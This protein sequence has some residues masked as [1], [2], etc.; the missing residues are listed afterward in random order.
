M[1][2]LRSEPHN[3]KQARATVFFITI[4]ILIAAVF[5]ISMNTGSLSMS[6]LDVIRTLFGQGTDQQKLALF[7][8]RLPRIVI[9]L[10]IGAGLA[11][12][13]CLLQG[14]VR[15]PI[16]DPGILGVN[17]G[18]GVMVVL[19]ITYFPNKTIAPVW[20]LPCL[21]FIGASLA[22]LLLVMLA[23]K[24]NIGLSPTKLI[25]SGIAVAAG[26][27]AL[28]IVLTIQLDSDNYQFL[29][30]FLAGSIWG[31]DWRFV[32]AL[33]PWLVII[34]P[35]V[36]YKARV[37]DLLNLGDHI[38]TGLGAPVQRARLTFLAAAVALAASCV[39]VS[40]SIGFVGLIAPH[41]ARRLIGTTHK[42]LLP[43]SALLGAL[44]VLIADTLS[45]VIDI[46]AGLIVAML[47]APYFLYL[48]A[49]MR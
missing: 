39:A 10:L 26:L 8:F 25:L 1:N 40:G 43:A 12:S 29:A 2:T 20:L 17:A 47:G 4:A 15:N 41:I 45:R 21:A 32:V 14:V 23:Y 42:V 11:V 48:L 16:A 22:A 34:L 30:A 38:A 33:L 46:P 6:P 7:D 37:L 28:M 3:P 49:K 24:K 18:A 9:S 5:I 19:F 44:L 13:G 27:N 31:T 36:F 35:F